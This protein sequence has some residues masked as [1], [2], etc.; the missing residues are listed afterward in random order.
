MF[1]LDKRGDLTLSK[2]AILI[3]VFTLVFSLMS[4]SQNSINSGSDFF[5][6][7]AYSLEDFDNDGIVNANDESPC[8]P[9]EVI[10][11]AKES[12]KQYHFYDSIANNPSCAAS[13]GDHGYDVVEVTYREGGGKVCVITK[14]NCDEILAERYSEG[15]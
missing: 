8:V 13:S 3:L 9:G 5:R 7:T 12:S 6:N 14:Q 15:E 11:N 2:I 1:K 10:V 4:F